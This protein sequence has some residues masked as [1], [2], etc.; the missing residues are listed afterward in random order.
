MHKAATAA[1][2]SNTSYFDVRPSPKRSNSSSSTSSRGASPSS[3]SISRAR[4]RSS[5]LT[6][7]AGR[8]S[9]TAMPAPVAA[10]AVATSTKSNDKAIAFEREVKALLELEYRDDVQDYMYDMEVCLARATES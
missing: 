7:P 4:Q 2:A 6:R 5:P 8:R 9:R 10:P 3:T 1:A